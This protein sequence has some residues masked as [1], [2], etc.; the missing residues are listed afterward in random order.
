MKI[1]LAGDVGGTKTSLGLF[2]LPGGPRLPLQTGTYV[3]A[4]Y[5]DLETLIRDFLN[6][7]DARVDAACFGVAGPIAAGR[8]K[9]T[10]LPW[11]LGEAELSAAL[12]IPEVWL[13][14]DLCA[15]AEAI[16]L[17]AGGED[18]VALNPG[19]ADP[20]GARAVIAPGTGLGQSFAVW[21]DIACR[22]RV[23]PSEGGHC[24]FAPRN[25]TEAALWRYLQERIGHVSCEHIC[26]GPGIRNI[27]NFLK[28]S[29][30]VPEPP[31]LAEEMS[32]LDDPTPLITR[33][34]LDRAQGPEICRKAVD[35]FLSALGAE[36]GNLALK[37]MAA[38]GVYVGG[39]LPKH[40]LPLFS[41][42]TFL[43]AFTDKGRFSDFMSRIPV[44]VVVRSDAAL[45][46]AAAHGLAALL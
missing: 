5:P 6:D 9:L 2:T 36:A 42:E 44:H 32:R 30:T 27:Y 25:D 15:V 16:P 38:G 24:D 12:H 14:N 35:I 29:G 41:Q 39:G 1:L 31:W 28:E 40:I 37:V 8:A 10:N 11:S 43:R 26:S 13:M 23:L 22:F 17:L 19:T 7:K 46:G 4:N 33:N 3:S 45:V 20:K 21:D 18:L 34:A